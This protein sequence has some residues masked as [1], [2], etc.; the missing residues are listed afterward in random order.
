MDLKRLYEILRETTWEFRKGEMIEGSGPLVEALRHEAGKPADKMTWPDVGGVAEIYMMP[1]ADDAPAGLEMVDCEFLKIGVDKAKAE[2][3]KA[4]LVR[5]LRDY[6]GPHPLSAGPSYI[7]VGGVRPVEGIDLGDEGTVGLIT[8]MRTDST[9][10]GDDAI[11]ETRQYIAALDASSGLATIW[12]PNAN[13]LVKPFTAAILGLLRHGYREEARRIAGKFVLTCARNLAQ[14]GQLWEKY[15]AL[16]GGIDV[17]DEYKM[18]PMMGWTAG[19]CLHAC[20][21]VEQG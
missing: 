8:Y 4:E 15:N 11:A 21:V 13:N 12:Y 6:R 17:A 9:R 1:H 18:P 5:L 19:G 10:V 7:E 14:S 2:P 3:L 20:D 16:T